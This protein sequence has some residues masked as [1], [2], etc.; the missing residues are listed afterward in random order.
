VSLPHS[1]IPP[2]SGCYRPGPKSTAS[3]FPLGGKSKR[4]LDRESSSPCVR[5][6]EAS[7]AGAPIP[8]DRGR[9]LYTVCPLGALAQLGERRLCKPEVTGSIPVRSIAEKCGFPGA[10]VRRCRRRQQRCERRAS[11]PLDSCRLESSELAAFFRTRIE[12]RSST[13]HRLR[14]GRIPAA[15]GATPSC[16]RLLPT[17]RRRRAPPASQGV[18]NPQ[19]IPAALRALPATSSRPTCVTCAAPR[20]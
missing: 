18:V 1:L 11:G 4:F 20:E 19:A 10:L 7:G 8:E 5:T 13:R 3:L 17:S 9:R 6:F 15:R 12:T 16:R 14:A 2:L